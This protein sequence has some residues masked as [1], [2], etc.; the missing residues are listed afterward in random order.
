ETRAATLPA[1]A[2][3]PLIGRDAELGRLHAL[4]E[5]ATAGTRQI[6]FLTGEA[7]IGK[8][9]VIETFRASIASRP[10]VSVATGQCIHQHGGAEALMPVLAALGRLAQGP[11]AAR[12]VQLLR[13][14]APGWLIQFPWLVEPETLEELRTRLAGTTPERMLRVFA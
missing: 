5:R 9:S 8:T 12:V 7:G 1:S 6:A 4:L 10:D 14:R 3:R 11:H 13:D 2:P